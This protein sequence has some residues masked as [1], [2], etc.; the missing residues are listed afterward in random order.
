MYV[1]RRGM[2]QCS[3]GGVQAVPLSAWGLVSAPCTIGGTGTVSGD[4]LSPCG[5]AAP[6]SSSSS[7]PS[8]VVMGLGAAAVGLILLYGIFEGGR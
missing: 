2:G 5:G 1:G 3:K 8:A 6:G 4:T 7:T